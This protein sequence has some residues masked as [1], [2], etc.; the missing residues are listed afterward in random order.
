NH[1]E[2]NARVL[3]KHGAA[4]VIREADCDGDSLY[5]TVREL[6]ADENRRR[7]MS[8]AAHEMAVVDSAERIYDA[9]I[10]LSKTR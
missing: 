6:L 10:R 1:Q 2:K 3:E 9:V 5:D 7:Q 4:V 8:K